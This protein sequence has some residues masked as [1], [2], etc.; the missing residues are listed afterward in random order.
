M[1]KKK[2]RI[3]IKF[4]FQLYKTEPETHE[5][6]KITYGEVFTSHKFSIGLVSLRIVGN[7]LMRDQEAYQQTPQQKTSRKSKKVFV[8]SLRNNSRRL[9]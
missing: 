4:N 2:Q 5:M 1:R 8:R 7:Q 3:C 9:R 6:L